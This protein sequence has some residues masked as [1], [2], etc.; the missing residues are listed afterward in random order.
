MALTP[1]HT[2]HLCCTM[3]PSAT[4]TRRKPPA[5]ALPLV[6]AVKVVAVVVAVCVGILVSLAAYRR[7]ST[8]SYVPQLP[9]ICEVVNS[10]QYFGVTLGPE[11]T[12]R[13]L[14]TAAI[15]LTGGRHTDFDYK[16][17]GRVEEILAD[18]ALGLQQAN[19]SNIGRMMISTCGWVFDHGQ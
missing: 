6:A 15:A 3:A 14:E 12:P 2:T 8:P 9:W 17:D 1:T 7:A 5:P 4:A 11:L 19:V 18:F 13:G 16:R 10:M